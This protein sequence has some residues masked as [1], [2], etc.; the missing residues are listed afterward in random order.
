MRT[1]ILIIILALYSAAL[2]AQDTIPLISETTEILTRSDT[3]KT[4]FRKK[5]KAFP[6]KIK[7]FLNDERPKPKK[8]LL[9]SLIL[10][11]SGQVYNKKDWKVPIAYAGLGGLTY[12]VAYN[13]RRYKRFRT[14]NIYRHDDDPTTIEEAATSNL[15]DAALRNLR[16]NER[17]KVERSYMGLFGFYLIIAADAFVDAHLSDFNMSDDLGLQLKPSLESQ[18]MHQLP[19]SGLSISY[20]IG[21]QKKEH[22]INYKDIHSFEYIP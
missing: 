2:F 6:A 12:L 5:I 17:R 18:S 9:M 1:K 22:K 20:R 11:G 14:A 19:V 15:E 21:H 4:P 13:T 16:N 10:P 8:A 7:L 3:I